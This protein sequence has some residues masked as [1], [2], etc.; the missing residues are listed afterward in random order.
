MG[1]PEVETKWGHPALEDLDQG[2]L[3]AMP[4]FCQV[5]QLSTTMSGMKQE[6][7]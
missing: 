4:W 5:T 3:P 6:L 1:S 7:S 2:H